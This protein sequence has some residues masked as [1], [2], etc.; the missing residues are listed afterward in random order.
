MRNRLCHGDSWVATP[1]FKSTSNL[2]HSPQV[3]AQTNEK[4]E[5]RTTSP[6]T[7]L[8]DA[9]E[10]GIAGIVALLIRDGG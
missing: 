4:K 5:K 10:F 6:N 8:H 9:G 1:A 2:A 7:A 3:P